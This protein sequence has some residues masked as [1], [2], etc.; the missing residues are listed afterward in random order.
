MCNI[1]NGI[2]RKVGRVITRLFLP[3]IISLTCVVVTV[4]DVYHQSAES[5]VSCS[6]FFF[7]IFDFWFLFLISFRFSFADSGG[8]FFYTLKSMT[9]FFLNDEKR[10]EKKRDSNTMFV[11]VWVFL[12]L[13]DFIYLFDFLWPGSLALEWAH[14]NVTGNW[15]IGSGVEILCV[16]RRIDQEEARRGRKRARYERK[17]EMTHLWRP[18]TLYIVLST[19]LDIIS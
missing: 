17:E 13:F 14:V 5:F 7:L 10:Q 1:L 4:I 15:R 9:I 2:T 12:F 18:P 11:C 8:Y 16:L 3:N 6:F 19:E